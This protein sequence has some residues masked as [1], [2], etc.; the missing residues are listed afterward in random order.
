MRSIREIEILEN[1]PVLLRTSLNV[2]VVHGKVED[3]FRLKSALPSIEYL[4]SRYARVILLSHISGTGT[5][6]LRPMYEA[7]RQWVPGLVWCP[8]STGSQ[9]RSAVR[10]LPPG[11]VLMLENLRRHAG[12]EK[13]D[14]EFAKE[15]AMLGDVFVQD[16]F[17]VCHREHAS[18]VGIPTL[19]PS[20]AGLTVEAEVEA[21]SKAL[22]P[23][24]PSLAVIGGAKFSTKEPVLMKLLAAYDKVFVGGALANDFL[25][26]KG[27]SV[28]SSRVSLEGKDGIRE[29][30]TNPRLLLP[31][32]VIVAPMGSAR[33]DAREAMLGDIRA[34]EAVLDAGPKTGAML[35]K[36]VKD[37]KTVLWNGPLGVYEDGFADATRTLARA[38][39]ASKAHSIIGG[40]DTVAV[41]EELSLA[42]QCSFLSTGGGAMLDFLAYGT[43]PGLAALK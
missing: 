8:V 24:R 33:E 43:L 36:L 21:L 23:R 32:D 27:I 37:S 12:E 22:S 7:M 11:G 2:P 9:A 41:L 1:I 10:E 31:L 19:L 39:A 25:K 14:T 29:L 20:Y 17:D 42:H 34:E 15:L 30:L 5:E 13:N 40:G 3:E 6:T 16:S 28:G 4:R 35:A 26:A 18:V 38:V